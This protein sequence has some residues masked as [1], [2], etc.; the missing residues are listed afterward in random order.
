MVSDSK[1]RAENRN[2]PKRFYKTA[3]TENGRILLDGRALKTQARKPMVITPPALARAVAAEWNAIATHINPD[4]MPL[5]R[6][7]NLVLDRTPHDRDALI[8]DILRYVETDLLCYRSPIEI[9][10]PP[11]GRVGEGP[12]MALSPPSDGPLLT[13]P[14]GG[15]GLRAEQDRLFDPLLHWALGQGIHLATTDTV[16][17]IAQPEASLVAARA[18]FERA[19]DHELTALAMMVPLLGSAILALAI[20]QREL[21]VEAAIQLARL[22]E[23]EQAKQWG[24]DAEAEAAWEFKCTDIVASDFFLTVSALK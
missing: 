22:D 9:S 5:T 2:H 20:W 13:S 15:E 8:A 12:D 3:T 16:M 24:S 14:P 4:R 10:L 1:A 11:R 17:P 23:T 21:S 7:V 6:L 18:L 19:T